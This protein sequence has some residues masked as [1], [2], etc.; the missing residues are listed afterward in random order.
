[1]RS[2]LLLVAAGAT[3]AML[4]LAHLVVPRAPRTAAELCGRYVLHSDDVHGE[5]NL[6]S[7]GTFVQTL[8]IKSRS[9]E[10]SSEGN[11]NYETRMSG[12]VMFGN[13]RFLNGFVDV[14]QS[15]D[16][17]KPADAS[18]TLGI[19]V[20][21]AEHWFDGLVLGR[22]DSWPEWKKVE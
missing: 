3:A 21:P 13:V 2:C 9:Q 16:R 18:R 6:R 11:W 22:V 5:M 12:G 17:L 19:T 20:L 4:L 7:D 1:M 14:F 15:P 8:A 10:I